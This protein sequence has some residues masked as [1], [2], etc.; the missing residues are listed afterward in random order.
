MHSITC[1]DHHGLPFFLLAEGG[2]SPGSLGDVLAALAFAAA[3]LLAT[4]IALIS[5]FGVG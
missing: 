1:S 4:A 2:L 3:G 5:G